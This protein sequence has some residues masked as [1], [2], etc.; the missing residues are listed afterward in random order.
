MQ[1]P[2]A[3]VRELGSLFPLAF[4]IPLLKALCA[5]NLSGPS[6]SG[7]A[8]MFGPEI[9]LLLRKYVC[10]KT[11]A[12]GS[13]FGASRKRFGKENIPTVSPVSRT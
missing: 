2:A 12:S 5:I 11:V 1:C 9:L 4:H 13:N 7:R 3:A 10:S 8:V 6:G